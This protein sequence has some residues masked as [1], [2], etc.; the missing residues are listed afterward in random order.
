MIISFWLRVIDPSS[1]N[2][3]GFEYVLSGIPHTLYGIASSSSFSGYSHDPKYVN[4]FLDI[5]WIGSIDLFCPIGSIGWIGFKGKYL[6][7]WSNSIVFIGFICSTVLEYFLFLSKF[8]FSFL[9]KIS[10]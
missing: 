2:K 3:N 10:G 9:S 6:V 1:F 7:V 4:S 5:G 8:F